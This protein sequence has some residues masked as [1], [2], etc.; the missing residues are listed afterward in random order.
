MFCGWVLRRIEKKV[1]LRSKTEKWEVPGR[2]IER[3]V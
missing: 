2:I 1:F 3:Y